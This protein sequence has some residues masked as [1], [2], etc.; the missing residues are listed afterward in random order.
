MTSFADLTIMQHF[1]GVFVFF[2]VF[3]VVYAFLQI[4]K[5]FKDAE[6]AKGIYT[7]IAIVIAFIASLSKGVFT[8][9]TTMTPWFATLIIFTFLV[10]FVIKIFTGPNEEFFSNM[11]K[12]KPALYISLIV[13]FAIILIGS[14]VPA[15]DQ[16][17]SESGNDDQQ[18]N[19]STF[20]SSITSDTT[21]IKGDG[22]NKATV[23]YQRKNYVDDRSDS[24][25]ED[26]KAGTLG[27]Q[28]LQ[29]ILHPQMLGTLLLLFIAGFAV[30]L[31]SRTTGGR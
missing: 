24:E 21:I 29:T 16:E 6:G 3:V 2:L 1:S 4:T 27:D 13:I 8:A 7:I 14:V 30:L 12:E 20:D 28:I 5:I 23:V 18:D 31:L 19:S 11:I 17:K 25:K 22:D 26:V 15:I 9:I 10:M